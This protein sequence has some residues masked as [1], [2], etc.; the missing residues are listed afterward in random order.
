[1]S[2]TTA[3][4]RRNLELCKKDMEAM[5]RRMEEACAAGDMETYQEL[6]VMQGRE[7]SKALGLVYTSKYSLID[8]VMEYIEEA[9]HQD[10]L[11]HFESMSI[12]EAS[13]DLAAWLG[14][15]GS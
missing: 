7:F 1:M 6:N 15:Y 3:E 9:E 5:V 14:S 2:L 13:E 8:R 10:G 11:E 4:Q 12:E